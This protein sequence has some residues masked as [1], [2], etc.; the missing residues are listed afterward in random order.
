MTSSPGLRRWSRLQARRG[1][2]HTPTDDDDDRRQR[3]LLVCPPTL[4][5]GGP[6]SDYSDNIVSTNISASRQW[7]SV[8]K[9][10][11]W[12]QKRSVMAWCYGSH[13]PD[14]IREL[15]G[16]KM[17]LISISN[18]ACDPICL[19]GLIKHASN[20]AFSNSNLFVTQNTSTSIIEK[21]NTKS[22]VPTGHKG[23]KELH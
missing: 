8:T 3:P 16:H 19:G 10:N 2:L 7:K 15:I 23:S 22:N 12:N 9:Q 1:V 18:T 5:V 13:E 20:F 17:S 11:V 14:E 21:S 6:V 4:R